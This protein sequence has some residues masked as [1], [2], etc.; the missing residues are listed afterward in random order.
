ME[1]RR[2]SQRGVGVG[3]EGGGEEKSTEVGG[4][5]KVSTEMETKGRE[6]STERSTGE[7]GGV[8]GGIDWRRSRERAD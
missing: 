1:V 5:R 3:E 2:R 7:R 4:K 8:Y 6:E